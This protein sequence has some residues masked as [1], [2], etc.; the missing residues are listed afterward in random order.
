[1][2]SSSQQKKSKILLAVCD[3]QQQSELQT[4]ISQNYT[5]ICFSSETQIIDALKFHGN[6]ISAAII[7]INKALPILKEIRKTTSLAGLPI[8]ISTD[9]ENSD[10]EDELLNVLKEELDNWK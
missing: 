8:L 9:Q 10:K 7:D 1:M 2:S 4:I 3:N 5:T 6:D